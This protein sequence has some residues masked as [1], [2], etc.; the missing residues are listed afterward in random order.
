MLKVAWTVGVRLPEIGGMMSLRSACSRQMHP[1][2]WIDVY[3]L[4]F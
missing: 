1:I 4:R 2:L 3:R